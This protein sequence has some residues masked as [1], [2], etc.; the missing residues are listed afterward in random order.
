MSDPV[1]S[2]F[3]SWARADKA[4]VDALMS[5]LSPELACLAGL[6]VSVWA[7]SLVHVGDDWRREILQHVEG[8]GYALALISPTYVVRPFIVEEELPRIVG[9][10]AVTAVLPV[11]LKPVPLD[12]SRRLHGLDLHQIYRLTTPDGRPR[13]FTELDRRGKDAFASTLATR[14]RDRILRDLG[15]AA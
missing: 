14:V 11:G 10:G 1:V 13:S 2:V 5:R 7:D 12:G 9:P 4:S 6:R 8:C 15:R 3:L